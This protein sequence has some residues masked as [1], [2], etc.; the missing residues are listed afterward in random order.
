MSLC[1][2][3]LFVGS[4]SLL[5]TWH[6][7]GPASIC[8]DS[9]EYFA[10]D[11]ACSNTQHKVGLLVLGSLGM[12]LLS[13]L[14]KQLESVMYFLVS[15]PSLPL[16]KPFP[17]LTRSIHQLGYITLGLSFQCEAYGCLVVALGEGRNSY[18]WWL[19]MATMWA[20]DHQSDFCV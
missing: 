6:R 3:S 19:P 20:H 4:P 11:E 5:S 17:S 7:L 15:T 12:K 16:G 2:A 10:G 13:Q 8:I 14:N 18:V 1:T 9:V